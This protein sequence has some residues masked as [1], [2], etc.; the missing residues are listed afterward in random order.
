MLLQKNTQLQNTLHF[1]NTGG[2]TQG[3]K[4]GKIY[5]LKKQ[6][7]VRLLKLWWLWWLQ[8]CP[9]DTFFR[10]QAAATDGSKPRI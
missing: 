3:D 8:I 7:Q 10:N 1:S 5:E 2:F 6:N 9:W 4:E